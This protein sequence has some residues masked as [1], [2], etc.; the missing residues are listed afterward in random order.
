V[1]TATAATGRT[2]SIQD[3][4]DSEFTRRIVIKIRKTL[5]GRSKQQDLTD[6]LKAW[7]TKR[8][9]RIAHKEDT[10]VDQL[11]PTTWKQGQVLL[12]DAKRFLSLVGWGYLS[13]VYMFDDD[14]YHLTRDAERSALALR[15]LLKMAGSRE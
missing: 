7:R 13:R 4:D 2:A 8:N 15:R 6:A 9:K 14:R 12:D 1:P 3:L 10:S 11:P 5:P